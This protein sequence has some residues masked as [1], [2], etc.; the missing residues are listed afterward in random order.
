[1]VGVALFALALAGAVFVAFR[2][3]W[4][5]PY[6]AAL[7]YLRL[8]DGLRSEFGLPSLFMG[9]APALV[10]LAF[11]R[12]FFRGTPVGPGWKPALLLLVTYGAVCAGSLLFASDPDRTLEALSNY[13]DGVV[14]V[15][16][17]TM[18]LRSMR[19][20]ER[21][22]QAL[23]LGGLLLGTLTVYQ[24]WTG[25]YDASFAGL[26]RAELRNV[27]DDT[28]GFRSEG[29]VS[30]NYFALVLVIA[31]PLAVDRML[32]EAKRGT[33]LLAAAALAS[34]VAS[35]VF[36][37]SRGGL[38]ALA[39]VC[40]PM[41][42]WIPRHQRRRMMLAGATAAV[43]LAVLVAPTSYGQRLAALGQVAGAVSGETPEDSALRGRISEMASALLMFADHPLI[44]VGYGNFEEHYPQYARTLALDGRR[45]ERQAHSLYLEILAET[46]LLGLAAFALLMLQPVAGL[47]RAHAA[48]VA[49]GRSRAAQQVGAFG[50][51]LFGYLA[52][53]LFLHLSYPRYLWLLVGIAFAMG[54]LGATVADEGGPEGAPA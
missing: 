47:R 41:A 27:F 34:M 46:G 35:I 16:V 24:Q 20:F 36:T 29:P 19:D 14:I 8:S 3:A 18:T 31:V 21:T 13:L 9:I 53:S 2:P 26:A 37:Y 30:A 32:H 54:A 7:I 22:L 15:L 1:M 43:V 42:L 25:A 6:F 38:V 50:I 12:W 5:A 4:S 40:L 51:A 44:G 39:A 11:G 17:M 23:L 48:L 10:L 49:R 45:E 52:G 28:S 33:R